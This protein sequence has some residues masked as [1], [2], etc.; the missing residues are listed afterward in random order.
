MCLFEISNRFAFRGLVAISFA[1]M[2]FCAVEVCQQLFTLFDD[3]FLDCWCAHNL[4]VGQAS[5]APHQHWKTCF[6]DTDTVFSV[7]LMQL[8]FMIQI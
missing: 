7:G 1:V 3:L 4:L 6:V 8:C 5:H 2:C